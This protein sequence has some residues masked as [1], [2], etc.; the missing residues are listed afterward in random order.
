MWSERKARGWVKN[1]VISTMQKGKINANRLHTWPSF[2]IRDQQNT[3]LPPRSPFTVL[4]MGIAESRGWALPPF[5]L[6]ATPVFVFPLS[7][8]CILSGQLDL[9]FILLLL[10]N[11]LRYWKRGYHRRV[12]CMWARAW[13]VRCRDR[14]GRGH[15]SL[16]SS[17]SHCLT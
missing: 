10:L 8:L 6:C 13:E 14:A 11:V 12:A 17:T 16:L 5:C 4:R 2:Q 15:N 3:C 9:F 1:W 7:C